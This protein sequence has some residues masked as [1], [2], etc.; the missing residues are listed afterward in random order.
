MDWAAHLLVLSPAFLNSSGVGG[1]VI[2]VSIATSI[3]YH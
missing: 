1:G 3:A 2:Q